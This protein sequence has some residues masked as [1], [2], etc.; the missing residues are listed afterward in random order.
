MKKL[1]KAKV[2]EEAG[3][4][5]CLK[6]WHLPRGL[7][8]MGLYPGLRYLAEDFEGSYNAALRRTEQCIACLWKGA[9]RIYRLRAG[10]TRGKLIICHRCGYRVAK[11][12]GS[13]WQ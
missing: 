12:G 6:V 11:V 8:V 2:V 5:V 7:K 4:P 13:F 1:Y 10:G 9:L 3:A